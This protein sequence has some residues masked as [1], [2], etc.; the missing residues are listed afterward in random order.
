VRRFKEI[1]KETI[2]KHLRKWRRLPGLAF[3]G[4]DNSNL[5]SIQGGI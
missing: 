3:E 1:W 2:K 4:Q 5:I